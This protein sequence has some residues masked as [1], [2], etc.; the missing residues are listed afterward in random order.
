MG[1]R[2]QCLGDPEGDA[3][4]SLIACVATARAVESGFV[5]E[6]DRYD[7]LEGYIYV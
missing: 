6:A 5:V 1:V 7:P 4:D 2:E 3:L